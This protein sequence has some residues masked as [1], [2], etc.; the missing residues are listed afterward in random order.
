MAAAGGIQEQGQGTPARDN[1]AQRCGSSSRTSPSRFSR[2][3][4]RSRRFPWYASWLDR[5]K[6]VEK[7]GEPHPVDHDARRQELSREDVHRRHLRRRPDGRRRRVLSRRPRSATGVRRKMERRADRRAAP[8]ALFRQAGRSV[9]RSRRSQERR[10]AAHHLGAS[11]RVRRG[12]QQ[13][14]G[15]LLPHV[16]DESTGEPRAVSQAR[17]LRSAAIRI[18]AARLRRRLARDVRQIRPDPQRTRPTPTTTARSAPTTSAA[19]T[20]IPR[21]A[22]SGG[23]RSSRSTRRIS[24]ACCT[25]SPTIRACPRT[26]A[27]R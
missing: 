16:P 24:R 22:T 8:S 15:L 19:T 21:R 23:A 20:I 7:S 5:E 2:T 9:C 25:F 11:R 10:A 13:S 12:R 26:C 3:R 18:V 17:W 6:G 4:R 27:A 14:A 1:K